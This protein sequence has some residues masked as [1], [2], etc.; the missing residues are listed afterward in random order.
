M[1]WEDA[2]SWALDALE[3]SRKAGPVE[4]ERVL[5]RLFVP[6]SASEMTMVA[7]ALAVLARPQL[8]DSASAEK[9]EEMRFWVAYSW[10][11]RAES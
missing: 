3:V 1:S 8:M 4:A 10:A 2:Y 9:I 6:L 7:V 5:A 11:A